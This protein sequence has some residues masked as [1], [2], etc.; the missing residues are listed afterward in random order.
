ML[1]NNTF[2]SLSG[3]VFNVIATGTED[4]FDIHR[5]SQHKGLLLCDCLDV[6]NIGHKARDVDKLV[7]GD[8]ALEKEVGMDKNDNENIVDDLDGFMALF[9]DAN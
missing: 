8:Q 1:D 2:I 4:V 3:L 6:N 9:I 5:Y 7:L